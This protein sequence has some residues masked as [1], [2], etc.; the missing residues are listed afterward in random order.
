MY[1]QNSEIVASDV[2]ANI[3]LDTL[4][5]R[6]T[7]VLQ[8][9]MAGY[10]NKVIARDC[11]I[12]ESTVKVHV[13]AILR[14]IHAKNRTQAAVWARKHGINLKPHLSSPNLTLQSTFANRELQKIHD[15][16]SIQPDTVPPTSVHHHNGS[17]G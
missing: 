1:K 8:K 7:E 13:K 4:S 9:L 5:S 11:G 12:T 15:G 6:E 10:P 14:K 2:G 16:L 17:K 3:R